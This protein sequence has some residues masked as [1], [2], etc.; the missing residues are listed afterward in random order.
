MNIL[1]NKF[2]CKII[3]FSGVIPLLRQ[4]GKGSLLEIDESVQKQID[5]LGLNIRGIYLFSYPTTIS[6]ELIE[7]KLY[8][9][10]IHRLVL[11]SEQI[12]KIVLMNV[13]S[14]I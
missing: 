9:Q 6:E 10:L 5:Q 12:L 1:S 11:D 8:K 3:Q 7:V 14:Y 13:L 4:Y 2:Q